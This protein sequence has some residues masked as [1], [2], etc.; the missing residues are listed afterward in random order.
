MAGEDMRKKVGT[1]REGLSRDV[2]DGNG[3]GWTKEILLGWDLYGQS[4]SHYG[5]LHLAMGD[6][7]TAT[8]YFREATRIFRDLGFL[9]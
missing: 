2:P 7:K 5:S 8:R 3:D 4:F 1:K 6:K 9:S